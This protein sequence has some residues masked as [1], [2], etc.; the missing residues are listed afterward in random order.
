MALNSSFKG[1]WIPLLLIVAALLAYYLLGGR[2]LVTLSSLKAARAD[3]LVQVAAH[4]LQTVAIYVALFA[5]LIAFCLPVGGLMTIAGGAL[6]GWLPGALLATAGS[7][8]GAT[9]AM[10]AFRLIAR[11]WVGRR[12]PGRAGQLERGI[13]ANGGLYLVSLRLAPGIPFVLINM[14][15][16][17]TTIPLRRFAWLSAVGG[18]PGALLFAYAGEQL[19]LVRSVGD[20]LSP[21]MAAAFVALAILPLVGKWLVYWQQRRRPAE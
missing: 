17:L 11:D 8:A 6:F 14:V 4:P 13:E 5:A 15:M 7:T 9:L 10:M 19:A 2:D 1:K 12:W 18:F 20:V 16:G 21:A 3:L